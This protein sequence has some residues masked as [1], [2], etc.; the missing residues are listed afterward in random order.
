MPL[1]GYGRFATAAAV[2]GVVLGLAACSGSNGDPKPTPPSTSVGLLPPVSASQ[3]DAPATSAPTRSPEEK[4][5]VTSYLNL[6]AA[7]NSAYE[8]PEGVSAKSFA[9]FAV[10]PALGVIL[11]DVTNLQ[12]SSYE[13]RGVPPVSRI[14]I[15]HSDLGAKP[16]PFVVLVDCP[17]VSTTWK[18][19][20]QATGKPVQV[21]SQEIDPPY[22]TTNE[23][24]H[25]RER[26]VLRTTSVDRSRTCSP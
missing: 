3:T 8:D 10:D 21:V 5:A 7:S 26:W 2:L 6:V 4:A 18:V 14:T 23:M 24:V 9:E 11:N 19:Y 17:T 25:I 1:G 20:S 13:F 22:A 15:S 16:Y 12:L